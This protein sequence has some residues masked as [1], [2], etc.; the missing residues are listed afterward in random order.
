MV[1]NGFSPS[2]T[3]LQIVLRIAHAVC[4]SFNVQH[5][6]WMPG[7]VVCQRTEDHERARAQGGFFCVE[8][9]VWQ[10]KRQASIGTR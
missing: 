10:F 5:S 9:N 6:L 8:L 3:E 2:L 7:H 4:V 1:S